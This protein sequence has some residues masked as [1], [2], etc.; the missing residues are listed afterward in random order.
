MSHFIDGTLSFSERKYPVCK[1]Q[2]GDSNPG[3]S[4]PGANAFST[5]SAI[6]DTKCFLT[7]TIKDYIY[8]L[9]FNGTKQLS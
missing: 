3:L 8:I 7:M 9:Y 4:D 5:M 2:S 1:W 6:R